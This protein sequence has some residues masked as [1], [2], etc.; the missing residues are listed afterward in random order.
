M[1]NNIYKESQSFWTWWLVAIIL[2][3]SFYVVKPI[4]ESNWK[5]DSSSYVGLGIFLVVIIGFVLMRLH[6]TIDGTGITI[7][8]LPFVSRKQW[9][10]DDIEE[11]YVTQY[12]ISDYGGWGYRIGKNGVAY[13]TKGK[14]GIQL[15]L[16]NGDRVMIG[17][18]HPKE[19]EKRI[20]EYKK[21]TNKDND[22]SVRDMH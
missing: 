16:V 15:K 12:S 22:K 11:I 1:K 20:D 10:W 21:P 5:V 14:Y 6:T 17:T 9:K 4:L 2:I 8:F 13:N 19:I 18:Q 3:V 7:R